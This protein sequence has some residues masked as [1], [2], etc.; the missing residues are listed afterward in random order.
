MKKIYIFAKKNTGMKKILLTISSLIAVFSSAQIWNTTGNN[1]TNPSTIFLGT[2]DAQPLIFRTNNSEKVRITL[3][4][5]VGVGTDNPTQKL[6]VNGSVTANER[7]NNGNDGSY[8]IKLN[9]NGYNVPVISYSESSGNILSFGNLGGQYH[10][11]TIIRGGN[12]DVVIEPNSTSGAFVVKAQSGNVGIG[13]T[14]PAGKLTIHNADNLGVKIEGNTSSY[15]GNDLEIYRQNSTSDIGQAA[16]IQMGDV[17]NNVHTMM[18]SSKDG[19]QF[20]NMSNVANNNWWTER[21]RIANNGNVGIGSV[22]PDSKLTVK[23]KIHAEEVKIDLQVPADYVFQKYYNGASDL[24]NDYKMLS[25]DEVEEFTKKYH[26]LPNFS[27]SKEIIENGLELG[28]TTNK[29]LEKIEELTLYSIDL[30][31]KNKEQENLIKS[32]ADILKSL[33]ERLEKLEKAKQK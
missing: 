2:I 6:D 24:K 30:N 19:F 18:Q 22:N 10:S 7:Y 33:N 9:S 14:S 29:L 15:I 5:S 26:H 25:L 27:S 8:Y 32:Q 11:K 13:T 28:I 21:L 23:G 12:G 1:G 17:Q 3:N 4:G 31:K 16:A 20:F